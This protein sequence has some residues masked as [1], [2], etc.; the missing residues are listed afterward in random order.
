MIIQN[1]KKSILWNTKEMY[2][3]CRFKQKLYT[4]YKLTYNDNDLLE[5]NLFKNSLTT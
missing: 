1:I 4:K 3:K 5:Y 2:N